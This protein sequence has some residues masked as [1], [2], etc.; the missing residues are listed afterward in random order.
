[1][2]SSPKD[3]RKSI[4]S[5]PKSGTINP[6]ELKCREANADDDGILGKLNGENDFNKT[7]ILKDQLN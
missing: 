7:S 2:V 4:G 5:S 6:R 1:M 3:W